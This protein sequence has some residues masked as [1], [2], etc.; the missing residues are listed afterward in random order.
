M[1]G[2]RRPQSLARAPPAV[3]CDF[4]LITV[5]KHQ[6]TGTVNR[7]MPEQPSCVCKRQ[8]RVLLAL[9]MLLL[10][11]TRSSSRQLQATSPSPIPQRQHVVATSPPPP[12]RVRT[13]TASSQLIVGRVSAT[14]Q[15]L[16]PSH[17]TPLAS[18]QLTCVRALQ[19]ATDCRA[20]Q[21]GSRRPLEGVVQGASRGAGPRRAQASRRP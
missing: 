7:S 4:L 13:V 9:S 11:P 2:I 16:S 18:Q 8:L 5:L 21:A 20:G 1:S 15:R 14:A 19:P 17:Y 10:S 12:L 6:N 3:D